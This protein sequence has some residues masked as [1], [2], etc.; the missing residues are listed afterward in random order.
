MPCEATPRI[1]IPVH[2]VS[3]YFLN[4]YFAAKLV[5]KSV[6]I[7]QKL[8]VKSVVSVQKLVVIFVDMPDTKSTRAAP[9]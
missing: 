9:C 4:Y 3:E 1:R 7:L 8:V 2:P 5:V 6:A